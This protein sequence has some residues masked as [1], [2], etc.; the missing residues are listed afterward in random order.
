VVSDPE[1]QINKIMRPSP[2]HL[3][4]YQRIN[5]VAEFIGRSQVRVFAVQADKRDLPETIGSDTDLYRLTFWRLLD[6]LDGELDRL[7]EAGMLMVDAR[8]DMHSSIQDRRLVD[9]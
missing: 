5:E 8:S 2:V 9:E 3:L 4:D 6:E 7:N 1:T